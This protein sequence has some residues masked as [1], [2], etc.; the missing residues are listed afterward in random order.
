MRI[1]ETERLLAREMSIGDLDF[2]ASLLADPDVM[3]YY[4]KRYSRAEAQGWIERQLVRYESHGHGFWLIEDRTT[5]APVG[6]VGLLLQ[7]VEDG[8]E[9]E[10]G[11]LVHRPFWRQGY[12]TEAALATRDLAFGDL[13]LSRV[14]SLIRPENVPSQGVARKLGMRPECRTT[15]AG[16]EHWLFSVSRPDAGCARVPSSARSPF[17]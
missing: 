13:G 2:I 8:E 17:L 7:R 3:R 9:P 12:A 4:P 15:F 11:Y 14:I 1:F 6:Q 10:V 5:G 16:L